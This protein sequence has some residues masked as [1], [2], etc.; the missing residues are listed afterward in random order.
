MAS[1]TPNPA[2]A[3]GRVRA[4]RPA[5]DRDLRSIR[6]KVRDINEAEV[7]VTVSEITK[8]V[9]DPSF[10]GR[11]IGV[12]GN[13]QANRICTWLI[14]ELGTETIEKRRIMC[15]NA[16]TFQGQERD[17]VFLSMVTCPDSAIAQT[18]RIYEQRF[19]RCRLSCP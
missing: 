10:V 7:D 11:S 15:G 13:A 2:P 12:I 1:E 16:A 8:T 17:I 4:H 18:S 6:A 19:K 3:P 14:A 5:T 9:G